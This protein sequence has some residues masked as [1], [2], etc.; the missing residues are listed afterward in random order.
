VFEKR[1]T[2]MTTKRQ[3]VD[4]G[5]GGL[6]GLPT[7][8]VA[9]IL[10]ECLSECDRVQWIRCQRVPWPV[11]ILR[12]V[13]HIQLHTSSSVKRYL[14]ELAVAVPRSIRIVLDDS[15]AWKR[16]NAM[17]APH[18][19]RLHIVVDPQLVEKKSFWTLNIARFPSTKPQ[20]PMLQHFRLEL[21]RAIFLYGYDF[22]ETNVL[23][24][25]V[26]APLQEL[27]LPS[28]LALANV[29]ALGSR[30][31]RTVNIRA[32]MRSLGDWKHVAT[33]KLQDLTLSGVTSTIDPELMTAAFG[34]LGNCRQLRRLVLP[35]HYHAGYP[36]SVVELARCHHMVECRLS[37]PY[38]PTWAECIPANVVETLWRAW[39]RLRVFHMDTKLSVA[40]WLAIAS[41]CRDLESCFL[42]SRGNREVCHVRGD[43]V[44][45]FWQQHPRLQEFPPS[46]FRVAKRNVSWLLQ[47]LADQYGAQ[48]TSLPGVQGQPAMVDGT[49]LQWLPKL[50]GLQG[51]DWI[52]PRLC[53][54]IWPRMTF[55]ALVRLHLT[56]PTAAFQLTN[57]LLEQMALSCPR[58]KVWLMSTTAADDA[59]PVQNEWTV[60]GLLSVVQ[61][62]PQLKKCSIPIELLPR[63]PH[64]IDTMNT[65]LQQ[66]RPG[67]YVS[68]SYRDAYG[69]LMRY[70][71]PPLSM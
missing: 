2:K 13:R 52:V 7:P 44:R 26:G 27:H 45:L 3:R 16:L 38:P 34:L 58:L 5:G 54:E 39:P 71:W 40:D 42:G 33:E 64:A 60:D 29:P 62:C 28:G 70:D 10:F 20:F 68:F 43:D 17:L 67:V 51:M 37:R 32:R 1:K 22:V 18:C 50:S 69:V 55:P 30:W 6:N 53:T 15:H 63:S 21:P 25:L 66:Q 47:Q 23:P 49:W 57:P 46:A 48:L 9:M 56:C 12:H 35:L 31:L 36:S 4:R 61:H 24:A 65:Y 59:D 11:D 14:K 41:H 19:R 8:V